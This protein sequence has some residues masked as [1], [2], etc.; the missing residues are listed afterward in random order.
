[1]PSV[2]VKTLDVRNKRPVEAVPA[3]QGTRLPLRPTGFTVDA[4]PI[5]FAV[6]AL[7]TPPWS[8]DALRVGGSPLPDKDLHLVRDAKLSWRDN[9]SAQARL[10]AEA[11]DERRL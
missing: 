7:T 8:Q 5:L 9:A 6:S 4:S 3:R 10:E 1:M 11:R 2:C